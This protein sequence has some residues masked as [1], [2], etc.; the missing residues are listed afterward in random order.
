MTKVLLHP[1]TSRAMDRYVQH[2]AHAVVL[3]GPTGVGKMTLSV[4]LASKLLDISEAGFDNYPYQKIIA[5]IDGKAIPIESIRELQSFLS[6]KIPST[7]PI[8]RI[9]II[10]DANL[11][12]T[13][14]QN[15]LLKT[16]EEPPLNTVL[17]LTAS[18]IESLLPT[19]RSRV[20]MLQVVAPPADEL[21]QWFVE[22]GFE[23]SAVDKALILGGGL[24]GLMHAL[25]S[26]EEDHPLYEATETAR[27]ILQSKTFERILLVDGL[28]KQ[29]QHAANVLFI[30]GQM[31][32]MALLR[33]KT[34]SDELRWKRI[35]KASYIAADQLRRNAQPKLVLTNLML[36]L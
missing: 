36:D 8:S 22:Q 16:L 21:K 31:A 28:S 33:S 34:A 12:T 15:A 13:E 9:I 19:I 11:L 35:M 23:Q 5:P 30:I 3:S 24:P 27:S 7:K 18:H 26:S 20:S 32:K 14:A 6:L 29:K 4:A 1:S 25:L 2:P 17:I 10:S